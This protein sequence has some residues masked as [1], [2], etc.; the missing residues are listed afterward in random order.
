MIGESTAAEVGVLDGEKSW[1]NWFKPYF[2]WIG[3]H[4][5][6][7]AFCYINWDWIK[8]KTWGSPGTWG[9]CRIEENEIVRKK[10]VR[11]LG[12]P[13]Y[14]HNQKMEDFLGKVYTY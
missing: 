14:I 5:Q 7:K 8:D 3:K 4:K 1:D 12:N 13:K 10:F 11:E 2:E 6:I 9:N